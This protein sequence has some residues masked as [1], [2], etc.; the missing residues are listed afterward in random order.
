VNVT[1]KAVAPMP[2]SELRLLSA[3]GLPLALQKPYVF[4]I[5][6]N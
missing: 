5:V 2:M 3:A 6:R 1:F 4:S